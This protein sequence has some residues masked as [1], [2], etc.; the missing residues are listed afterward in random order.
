MRRTFKC[1][2]VTA[3]L[4][5]LLSGT[6]EAGLDEWT[7]NG[8]Y[9]GWVNVLAID[10]QTPTTL[11]AGTGGGVF[12]S[13]DSGAH[14]S[15]VNS[16]LRDRSVAV[17]VIDAETPTTL[18]AASV[19]SE[20]F[21]S[22][23]GGGHWT[24]LANNG[25]YD[26]DR[27]TKS[28]P[29]TPDVASLAVDPQNPKTLYAGRRL[30]GVY[31]STD[32]GSYWTAVNNGLIDQHGSLPGVRSLAIDPQT[33][34]TL[35]IGTGQQNGEPSRGIFRSTD[36]GGQWGAVNNG[37]PDDAYVETLALD[38]QTPTTLY[39]GTRSGVFKSTD[40]GGHWIAA[41]SGL[42]TDVLVKAL[43][44]D[45]ATPTT[46]YAASHGVFKSTD[47]GAHW[48]LAGYTPYAQ[49]LAIDPQT[50]TTLYVGA[51]GVSRT[52]DGGGHWI[53]VNNGLHNTKIDTL[54]MDPQ[55]PSTVYT[56]AGGDLFKSING[57]GHWSALE[58]WGG[59]LAIDPQTPTIIYKGG[60]GVY[61]S[62]DGGIHWSA[63]G[64]GL[65]DDASVAALAI[66]PQV[67][68]TLYAGYNR[69]DLGVFKTT[70]GGDHWAASNIGLTDES[71]GIPT[72]SVLAID[73]QSPTTV[74]AGGCGL[75]RSIDGGSQWSS[76]NNGLTDC[77]LSWVDALAIDPQSPS[78]VYAGLT[79]VGSRGGVFKSTDSGGH[80]S[81][82]LFRR[83][84][85]A[86]AI[87]PQTPTTLYAGTTG[88]LDESCCG[89]YQS[90]DGG[91]HWDA[92]NEGLSTL[93]ISALAID[94]VTPTTL[95]AGTWGG[96]V[97]D[98]QLVSN[99]R[100]LALHDGRFQV[101]VDWRDFVGRTGPGTI[102]VVRSETEEGAI[103]RS[104]DSAV[105][106]FFSP[107]NW[108]LLVKVLDGRA[109]ND[110][111]WVF[112]AAATNV[113]LTTTVTDTSCGSTLR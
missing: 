103:L 52:T 53:D 66:D 63:S 72:I 68:T 11:Y 8:P 98:I 49:A 88:F 27:S 10:P 36:G 16:G 30:F 106:Q 40:S 65:P 81:Q 80:W 87:D 25:F 69:W 34:T 109:L 1:L 100:T 61:K 89:V 112:L 94:P 90:T 43:V 97:F 78:T 48:N 33:P 41:N 59:P 93:V 3:A 5:L 35:Y 45:P 101:E 44:I 21:I 73:P 7:S 13:T 26:F 85:L 82:I 102:A 15:A 39:A 54:A 64:D 79:S 28:S 105:A 96:G 37:L 46:L 32:G 50:P 76:V 55:T 84:V 86:L 110:H 2:T 47:G 71:G 42:P 4:A 74:Y 99:R 51:S 56:S 12:K 57:G 70:D 31:K 92:V 22:M 107:D 108:E 60:D 67:P 23:N 24:V 14:W 17:L 20:V 91:G 18:Y 113:E 58:T 6:A 111:F 95:Y 38:P 19:F 104:Q 77:G 29:P 9:G 62:T 75:F 83:E